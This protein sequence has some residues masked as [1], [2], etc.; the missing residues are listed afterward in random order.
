MAKQPCVSDLYAVISV[1]PMI[2]AEETI[3]SSA[4]C[5]NDLKFSKAIFASIVHPTSPLS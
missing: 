1:T 4:G 2:L 3:V 5:S